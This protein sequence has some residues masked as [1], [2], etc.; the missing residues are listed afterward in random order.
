[1][2]YSQVLQHLLHLKLVSLRGMPPPPERFPAGYNPNAQCKFHSG[3][4]GHDMENCWNLKYKVQES[5][6]SKAIQFTP[7]NG[8]NVIQ[9][10]MPAHVGPIV[11]VV[12]DGENLNLIMDVNLLSNP[13]SC[14]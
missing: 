6:D 11:N 9:N 8:P 1:M 5:L 12:E 14:V 4:I 3:G 2:S 13:L 10:P 7:D